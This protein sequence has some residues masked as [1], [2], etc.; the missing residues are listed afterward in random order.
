MKAFLPIKQHSERVPGKNFLI[1][2]GKPLFMWIVGALLDCKQISQIVIDTDSDDQYFLELKNVDRISLKRRTPSLIGDDV[3][4]NLLIEDFLSDENEGTFLMTH[5]TNPF[6]SPNTIAAAIRTF[7][8]E[9][10]NGFDSLVSVNKFQSRFYDE[11]F[12]PV[13]HNP[14]RLLRTQD[15]P[16]IYEE[17]SC[18]YVFTKK[19]FE[20]NNKNRIG[21]SPFLFPT[22]KF[23][24][25]DIDTREDWNF[26]EHVASQ[27]DSLTDSRRSI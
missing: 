19:S 13:N 27:F 6:L 15:L 22:P 17:N 12:N 25:I 16:I 14:N 1:L 20:N 7:E 10:R 21:K 4:M 26:A 8:E 5:A 2:N 24:S 9:A 18:L 3:S 11:G 23:E